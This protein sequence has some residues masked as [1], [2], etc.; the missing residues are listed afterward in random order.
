MIRS[1]KA[2]LQHLAKE[3]ADPID[4]E[5]RVKKAKRW[6]MSKWTDTETHFVPYIVPIIRSVSQS[7]QLRLAIDGSDIGKGCSALMVSLIWRNRAIPLVWFTRDAPKGHFSTE[8]HLMVIEQLTILL[9]SIL[10]QDCEVILLGDGEFD[11]EQLQAKCK[12]NGWNYVLK[13]AKNIHIADHPEMKDYATFKQ[14]IPA[15]GHTTIWMPEM[16]VFKSGYGLVNVLYHHDPKYKEPWYLL[17]NIDYMP[18][19]VQLYRKRYC[20]ETFFGDIKSRGFNIHKT[21]ISDAARLFNLLLVAAL[22]FILTVLFEFDAR[23]SIH[24]PMFCRKDRVDSYSVFQIGLLGLQFYVKNTIP[25][26]FQ[27][28]KN[29]P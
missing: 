6:I 27:F 9:D 7:G 13:T 26:P 23:R 3:M 10:E 11:S 2:S 5:S 12:S 8:A 17:T 28:S 21:R 18:K 14:M 25:T 19:A 15:Y 22:A 16:Y 20:I 24:L 1:G 29:F 4:L